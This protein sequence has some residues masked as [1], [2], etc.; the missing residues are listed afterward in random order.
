VH[1]VVKKTIINYG[2]VSDFCY[3]YS[4]MHITYTDCFTWRHWP[5][6]DSRGAL[7]N[8]A[9]SSDYSRNL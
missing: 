8:T 3:A 6:S 1:Q 4:V 2:L 7:D 9:R 5:G